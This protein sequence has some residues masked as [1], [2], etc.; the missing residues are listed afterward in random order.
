MVVVAIDLVGMLADRAV[1]ERGRHEV[2]VRQVRTLQR[3]VVPVEVILALEAVAARACDELRLHPGVRHFCRLARRA[4][5]RLF[6]R[7]VVEVETGAAGALGGVDAFDQHTNLAG[8]A[9]GRVARLRAGAVTAHVDAVDRDPRRH[10]EQRPH[11]AGV[12]QRLKLLH[13]EVLLNTRVRGVD[14][15]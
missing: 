3:V 12:R 13:L 14:D 15:R 8:L 1:V 2:L 7:C 5:E 11:V 4:D 9:V 6:E 10:G